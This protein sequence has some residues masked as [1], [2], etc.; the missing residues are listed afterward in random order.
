MKRLVLLA[1]LIIVVLAVAACGGGGE[2]S[3]APEP[4]TFN[5]K[6]YDEFRYDPK[7]IA[8]P[9]GTQVTITLENVGVLEHSWILVSS[10][11][12]PAL[13]SE[14][15]ALGGAFSGK[16][17]GGQNYTFSFSAPPPGT[18]QIVCEVPGHAVGGMVGTFT[19]TP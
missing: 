3:S 11:K 5:V 10:D 15:D 7:D 12:D 14:A 8:V 9:A 19:V 2:E 4:M 1:T 13:V 6:G 17:A 16:I 18:Y